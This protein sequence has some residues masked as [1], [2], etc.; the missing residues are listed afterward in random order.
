MRGE[1]EILLT[2]DSP[3]FPCHVPEPF[4]LRHVLGRDELV[5]VAA[6]GLHQLL[7]DVADGDPL[8]ML[9]FPPESFFGQVIRAEALPALMRRQQVV[10]RCVSEFAMSL[11]ELAMAGEGVVWL[12]TSLIRQDLQ[13]G[14]LLPLSRLSP[15]LSLEVVAFFAVLDGG[16]GARLRR[17]FMR[18]GANGAAPAVSG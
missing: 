9:C 14:A 10:V 13:S 3:Q 2:Y 6:P 1:A 8:P 18:H 16:R 4:A 17:D 7:G 15:P 12:P 5:L 11:R